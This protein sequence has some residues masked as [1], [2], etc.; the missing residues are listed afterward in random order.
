MS[1]WIDANFHEVNE[2]PH[3]LKWMVGGPPKR[4][5]LQGDGFGVLPNF[6]TDF[7]KNTYYDPVLQAYN[8]HV[9]GSDIIEKMFMAEAHFTFN[10]KVKFDQAGLFV[11]QDETT[12]LKA[13]VEFAEGKTWQSVVVTR[14]DFSDWS[15]ASI[16]WPE[17]KDVYIRVYRQGQSYVV[18]TSENGVDYGFVRIAHMPTTGSVTVGAMTCRPPEDEDVSGSNDMVVV[19][20]SYKLAEN[21][22]YHHNNQ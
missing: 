20:H 1:S 11:G 21:L 8:G 22:G 10:P 4:Y 3:Q 17:G 15:K 7:W 14:G 9:L 13:G 6:Q 16:P 12:W 19:F 18:E 2:I 5:S